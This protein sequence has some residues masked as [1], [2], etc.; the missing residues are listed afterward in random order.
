MN[1]IW[2]GVLVVKFIEISLLTPPVGMNVFVLKAVLRDVEL[3]T[4]FK[5]VF[6]FWLADI[7]RLGLLLSVPALS[8]WLVGQM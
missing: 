8:L 6:P 7:V 1:L 3:S 5:G 2:I 4:I